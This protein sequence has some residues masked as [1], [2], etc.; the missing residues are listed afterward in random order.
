MA[1]PTIYIVTPCR[2][3]AKTINDTITSVV[4]QQGSFY[5]RYHIQDCCSTDETL[6]QL[7]RWKNILSN[8]TFPIS[9]LG[10]EFSYSIEPDS[11]LYDGIKKGFEKFNIYND[12]AFM[13]WLNADDIMLNGALSS[14]VD[15]QK[16]LPDVNW[17]TGRPCQYN[18]N[19]FV[20]IDAVFK[21]PVEL[22]KNGYCESRFLGY[23]IQQEGTFWKKKLWDSSG[24]INTELKYAGDFDL[25]VKFAQ[26]DVLWVFN[27]PLGVFRIREGQLSANL[28]EYFKEIDSAVA[29]EYKE[30][31]W[32]DS[33]QKIYT[34]PNELQ[35]CS[36]EIAYDYGK[37]RY[38]K[39]VTEFPIQNYISLDSSQIIIDKKPLAKIYNK[40]V[41]LRVIKKTMK[42]I[43]PYGLIKL[44]QNR[45]H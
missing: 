25:W 11:G 40:H 12:D 26:K 45:R 17:V 28:D 27:G 29:F 8:H 18:G 6:E 42:Y 37:K 7:E 21:Y 3:A 35:Y 10:I 24:G 36:A 4:T 22:V 2:N 44:Y 39:N 15:I 31:I 20:Y 34:N 13:T 32:H 14:I 16:M 5:V 30:K 38:I 33:L 1:L 43:T 41:M 19:S 23:F 9:C